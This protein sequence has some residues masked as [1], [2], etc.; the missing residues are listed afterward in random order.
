MT[1]SKT[2]AFFMMIKMM[3]SPSVLGAGEV[4]YINL[5]HV[6]LIVRALPR[7]AVSIPYNP[8]N[9][10]GTRFKMGGRDALMG[11]LSLKLVSR[12]R[13]RMK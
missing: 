9:I 3:P 8:L 4:Q 11:S 2:N 6:D 1:G 7:L 12:F 13:N 5:R 10:V